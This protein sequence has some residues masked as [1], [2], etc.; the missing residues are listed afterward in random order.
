MN[1]SKSYFLHPFFNENSAF[2]HDE[3]MS[4]IKKIDVFPNDF[5]YNESDLAILN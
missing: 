3:K 2:Y 5:E 4:K 1:D